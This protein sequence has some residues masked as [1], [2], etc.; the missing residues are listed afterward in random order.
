[1]Q[2]FDEHQR[3]VICHE[4]AVGLRAI[5][6]VHNT[7]LGPGLGG[8]RMWPFESDEAALTDVLRLSRG[9]TYKNSLAGL[10]LGGGKTVVIGDSRTQKTP[11]LFRALGRV[12]DALGGLYLA[13]EDV[14]T[15]TQDATE[16]ARETR[17]IT[18]LPQEVGGSGDPS[19]MTAWGVFVGMRAAL[20][21]AGLDPSF[22]GVSVVVQGAGH[23]GAILTRHLLAAGAKVTV[24]DIH[25]DRVEALRA[26]GAEVADPDGLHAHA[27]DI[28]SPCAL[29]AVV[30]PD[31]IDGF[32]CRVIAGAANNQLLDSEMG[33]ALAAR[34]IVYAP[35]FAINA[36]G[37]INI[38]EELGKPYDA[39][40][41][42]VAVGQIEHSLERVFAHAREAGIAPHQAAERLAQQRIDQAEADVPTP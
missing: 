16:V 19:P 33:D 18:G 12:I 8:I 11:E 14:G 9:M 7:V 6:A 25:A 30:R 31:T 15:T 5:I 4:P 29:G 2:L 1:M 10:P 17:Y 13:A 23:V 3:I 39:A 41:A 34:G 37:V 38:G 36:G 24:A 27:C 35:D 22:A 20:R 40:R 28:F 32:R 42:E 21:E 26:A